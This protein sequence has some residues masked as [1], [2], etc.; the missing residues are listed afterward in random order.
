MKNPKWPVLTC[1]TFIYVFL[2]ISAFNT[3]GVV[4]S[5]MVKD[6]GWSFAEAGLSYTVLGVACGLGS[7]LPMMCLKKIGARWTMAVGS[8]LLFAG[9]GLSTLGGDITLF[10]VAMSLVG[11]GFAMTGNLP[12]LWIIGE[13]FEGSSA[14]I[15]G[16]YM[17]AGA[18][19]SIIG[20]PLVQAIVASQGWR[21]H[22]GLMTLVALICVLLAAVVVRER[23]A[24]VH[25]EETS[26]PEAEA[27]EDKDPEWEFVPALKTSAFAVAALVVTLLLTAVTTISATATNHL[28]NFGTTAQ[29]AAF[30]LG[31]FALVGTL[32]KGAAGTL[33]ERFSPKRLLAA[34]ALLQGLGLIT[35]AG[36]D[37]EILLFAWGLVFGMGWGASYVATAV[38][39]I[40][41]FGHRVGARLFA[42]AHILATLA[43]LGP[44]VAGTIADT[45]GTFSPF[46][47]TW[48]G[49]FLVAVIPI[50]LMRPPG[51]YKPANTA[52]QAVA[53]QA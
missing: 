29:Q 24:S 23:K 15:I 38:L 19:G 20:P 27:K 31:F 1:I 16:F 49:V 6:L 33:C 5:Y 12:A 42:G 44:L 34:G 9:Y 43:A 51:A 32:S 8:V 10:Y 26:N 35:L 41:F 37:T 3:L 17:M 2:N 14:R 25:A 11:L 22:W 40:E 47:Y 39:L 4:L 48:G 53:S 50:M 13:W 45:Y 52:G 30:S 18:A 36:A 7:L 21:F 28:M 46:F